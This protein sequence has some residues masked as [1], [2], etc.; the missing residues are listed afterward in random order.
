[1][2]ARGI[3]KW[4]TNSIE[5]ESLREK[6]SGKNIAVQLDLAGKPM[7]GSESDIPDL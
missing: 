1:V 3:L 6:G 5:F 2:Y 4:N 7:K